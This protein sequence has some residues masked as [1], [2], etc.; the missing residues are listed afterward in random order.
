MN[1]GVTLV[2]RVGVMYCTV[3]LSKII[4]QTFYFCLTVL[5]I[6]WCVL[7]WYTNKSL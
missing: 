4:F 1:R 7:T 2:H 6:W 3:L 5:K